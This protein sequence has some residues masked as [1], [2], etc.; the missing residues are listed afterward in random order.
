MRPTRGCARSSGWARGRSATHAPTRRSPLSRGH[1][2]SR[3]DE[4]QSDQRPRRA[5]GR[6][7]RARRMRTRVASAP[8]ALPLSL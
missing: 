4:R 7:S 2:R 3:R 8:R 1:A 5:A 6:R